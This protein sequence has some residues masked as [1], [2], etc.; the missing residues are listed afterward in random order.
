MSIVSTR[1]LVSVV[2]E[3]RDGI[4]EFAVCDRNLGTGTRNGQHGARPC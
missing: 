4:G 1:D 3:A 2:S